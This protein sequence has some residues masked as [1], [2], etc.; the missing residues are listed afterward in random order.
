[1][2]L[3]KETRSKEV[4]RLKVALEVFQQTLDD[5]KTTMHVISEEIKIM[6]RVLADIKAKL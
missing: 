2:N 4:K 6:K 1:M 3:S 5:T